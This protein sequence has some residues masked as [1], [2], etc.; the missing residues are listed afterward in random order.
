MPTGNETTQQQPFSPNTAGNEAI[1]VIVN[2]DNQ[3]HFVETSGEIKSNPHNNVDTH[4][5]KG[6]MLSQK[7]VYN[8]K[9]FS[10]IDIEEQLSQ[11][12]FNGRKV[13][14]ASVAGWENK[15]AS[16]FT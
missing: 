11:D 3:I 12:G 15:R 7:N 5:S 8:N 2:T 10:N 9:K 1:E 16:N 13:E 6:G 14:S 4:Q